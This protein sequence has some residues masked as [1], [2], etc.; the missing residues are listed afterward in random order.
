MWRFLNLAAIN[1]K[2][3]VAYKMI[4]ASVLTPLK[5]RDMQNYESSSLCEPCSIIVHYHS[6]TKAHLHTNVY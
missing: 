1:Y 2:E 4:F 3:K 5:G 6:P